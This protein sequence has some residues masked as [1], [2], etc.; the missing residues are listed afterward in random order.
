M[1][2]KNKFVVR[3][4]SL[5]SESKKTAVAYIKQ[6]LNPDEKELFAKCEIKIKGIK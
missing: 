2:D 6:S 1:I 3:Q 5:C 4:G